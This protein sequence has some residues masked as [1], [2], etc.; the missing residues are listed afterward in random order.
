LEVGV[1]DQGTDEIAPNFYFTTFDGK[2]FTLNDYRGKIVLINFWASWCGPCRHETPDLITINNEYKDKGV[3]I[4]GVAVNDEAEPAATFAKSYN[5]NYQVGPDVN[6]V[7]A[8]QFQIRAMPTTVIVGADGK[9]LLRFPGS[10]DHD[11]LQKILDKILSD[12]G[13]SGG[14]AA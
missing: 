14:P 10:T 4:A 11:T 2:R 1:L 8:R 12:S 5:V 9:M 3:V 13:K 7:L 6:D